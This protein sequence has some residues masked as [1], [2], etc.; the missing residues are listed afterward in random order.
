MFGWVPFS[1]LRVKM[2]VSGHNTVHWTGCLSVFKHMSNISNCTLCCILLL[3]RGAD[4]HSIVCVGAVCE[5]LISRREHDWQWHT[6]CASVLWSQ[7]RTDYYS[8][9]WGFAV[10]CHNL[11]LWLLC[12]IMFVFIEASN[13]H[14]VPWLCCLQGNRFAIHRL[15]VRVLAGHHCIV[16]LGKLLTPVYLCHQAT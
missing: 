9:A 16:A 12:V 6:C 14:E 4:G 2:S 11:L 1:D 15:R 8:F 3:S 7:C 10:C 13:F 5:G